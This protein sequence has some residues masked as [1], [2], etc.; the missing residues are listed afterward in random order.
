MGPRGVPQ[1]LRGP[2]ALPLKVRGAAPFEV[3]WLLVIFLSL[4]AMRCGR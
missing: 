3:Q 4:N 2:M 1:G